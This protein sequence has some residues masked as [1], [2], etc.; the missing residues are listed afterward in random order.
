MQSLLI[1]IT[2]I[3]S[4]SLILTTI[5]L[6]Q[7][8]RCSSHCQS[9]NMPTACQAISQSGDKP[10]IDELRF[11]NR[12]FQTQCYLNHNLRKYAHPE[13]YNYKEPLSQLE[14]VMDNF[15]KDPSPGKRD[16]V[17]NLLNIITSTTEMDEK[18]DALAERIIRATQQPVF[19]N[20]KEA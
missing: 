7:V 18:L 5:C 14:L 2:I 10:T 4:L 15:K 1:A 6:I 8:L 3:A 19:Q 9:Q 11:N 16:D 12:D 13:V 17:L 20:N